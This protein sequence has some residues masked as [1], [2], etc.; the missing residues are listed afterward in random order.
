MIV[1][2][3]LKSTRELVLISSRIIT[4]EFGLMYEEGLK[5]EDL[6]RM[7]GLKLRAWTFWQVDGEDHDLTPEAGDVLNSFDT[8]E[9]WLEVV[10]DEELL[11]GTC[12]YISA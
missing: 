1:F 2:C 4:V 10:G 8:D 11:E 7:C 9:S 6:V 3:S 5:T 12:P